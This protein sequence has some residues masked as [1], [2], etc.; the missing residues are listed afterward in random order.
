MPTNLFGFL[1]LNSPQV[2]SRKPSEV[3]IEQRLSEVV[4][5]EKEVRVRCRK[6]EA[7]ARSQLFYGGR[8]AW[9]TAR[10]NFGTSYRRR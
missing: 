5:E 3:K 7:A 10:R 4:V 9:A 2:P 1:V 8:D 6:E